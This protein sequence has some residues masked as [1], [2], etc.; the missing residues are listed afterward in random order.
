MSPST[1]FARGV[2]STSNAPAEAS[3]PEAIQRGIFAPSKPLVQ[4]GTHPIAGDRQFIHPAPW[5]ST[6]VHDVAQP[7]LVRSKP[8]VNPPA[9]RRR[10]SNSPPR[11]RASPRRRR[12]VRARARDETP[13]KGTRRERE[14]SRADTPRREP[15]E[16]SIDA[17]DARERGKTTGENARKIDRCFVSNR[18][19]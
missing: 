2:T 11:R 15:R 12:E 16:G 19:R 5:V 8:R 1:P 3:A 10:E 13:A 17:R 14:N 7:W 18:R 4:R 6:A 9:A